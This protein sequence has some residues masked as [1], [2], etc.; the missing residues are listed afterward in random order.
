[1]VTLTLPHLEGPTGRHRAQNWG[2]DAAGVFLQFELLHPH[3][4][5]GK[6][7]L[8]APALKTGGDAIGVFSQSEW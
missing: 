1:M 2:G 7:L 5:G 3:Y 8:G 6:V 4:H